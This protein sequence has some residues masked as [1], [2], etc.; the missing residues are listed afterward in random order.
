MRGTNRDR[1]GRTVSLIGQLTRLKVVKGGNLVN[2]DGDD[3]DGGG[4][5]NDGQ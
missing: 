4:G 2:G 3:D 1:E 5:Q